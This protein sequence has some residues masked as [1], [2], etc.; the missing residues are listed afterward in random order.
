MTSRRRLLK[1][2]LLTALTGLGVVRGSEALGAA[3]RAPRTPLE[4]ND[5][6]AKAVAYQQDARKVD[7]RLFATYRRGQSCATCALIEFGTARLR[8]CSLFPG[9][10]VAAAGWCSA[11]QLRGGKSRL[12][13]TAPQ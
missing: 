11:W 4:E 8:G 2:A 12:P 7:P 6:A 1:T 5:A 10:L 13:F 3:P 9:K